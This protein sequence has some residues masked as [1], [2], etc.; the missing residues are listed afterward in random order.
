V[1]NILNL[2]Y[3]LLVTISY[4]SFVQF[5]RTSKCFCR[6]ST[7]YLHIKCNYLSTHSESDDGPI[8]PKHVVLWGKC[9]KKRIMC[10]SRKWK[11]HK[12]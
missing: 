5:S 7:V 2:V 12:F 9:M 3:L 6:I 11:I 4:H 1:F 10:K 8:R